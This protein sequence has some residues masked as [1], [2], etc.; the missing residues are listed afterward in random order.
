MVHTIAGLAYLYGQAPWFSNPGPPSGYYIGS[1]FIPT[2][3][4][5]FQPLP[6]RAV[7][8]AGGIEEVETESER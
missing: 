5:G 1:Q 6:L 4:D 7:P 3:D 8:A 2:D